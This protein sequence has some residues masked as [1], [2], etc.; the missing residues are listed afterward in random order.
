MK[1]KFE[2][3][4][5]LIILSV[6][7]ISCSEDNS[8]KANDNNTN[9]TE[10]LEENIKIEDSKK[11][12]DKDIDISL[13]LKQSKKEN[14]RLFFFDMERLQ[15]VYVDK[16]IEIVDG[17]KVSALTKAHQGYKDSNLL[18]LSDKA[19]IKSAKVDGDILK[20][21]FKGDFTEG[22]MLGTVTESGLAQSLVNTYGYNYK[23]EK[24]ALYIND[25][26]Y[27]GLRGELPEGYYKVS[28]GEAR[29]YK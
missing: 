11:D 20:V 22:M 19:K 7:F 16:E 3:I 1:R 15:E 2:I 13:N 12:E 14:C 18:S 6:T 21:Y 8:K 23:V 10:V 26:L 24:V 25:E 28:A 29:P 9:S 27:T 4:L 5:L 17:A